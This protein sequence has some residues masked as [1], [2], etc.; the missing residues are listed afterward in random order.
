VQ[1]REDTGCPRDDEYSIDRVWNFAGGLHQFLG[2]DIAGVL[3][4]RHD[5][6]G[7]QGYPSSN[8]RYA[9][10]VSAI[11]NFSI[12]GSQYA[13]PIRPVD[14]AALN[15]HKEARRGCDILVNS[16]KMLNVTA[17]CQFRRFCSWLFT[18][19]HRMID[20]EVLSQA[21]NGQRTL[22]QFKATALRCAQGQPDDFVWDF[23]NGGL[24]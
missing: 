24:R 20:S 19:V 22:R 21:I 23:S 8:R 6:V 4:Q 13:S 12:W 15:G 18:D 9:F 17:A 7:L 10:S 2:C 11:T 3:E 16:A 1:A 5:L 14:P